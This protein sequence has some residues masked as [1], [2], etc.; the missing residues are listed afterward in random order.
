MNG[1]TCAINGRPE[2]V[3]WPPTMY[4]ITASN[5]GGKVSTTITIGVKAIAP[6]ELV[7]TGGASA[8]YTAGSAITI[9]EALIDV[10]SDPIVINTVIPAL[11]AG[12]HFNAE[13]G[14]VSGTPTQV[15]PMKTYQFVASNSGGAAT[16]YQNIT[17]NVVAP[18]DL[19]YDG[20]AANM[21]F[22]LGQAL[23]ETPSINRASM[24]DGATLTY[25]TTALPAG[26]SLNTSTG[27]FSGTPT[28]LM[29]AGKSS[30]SR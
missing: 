15:T 13:Y 6:V 29:P 24:S 17:V 20:G 26:L 21:T 4:S 27:V 14:I 25:S 12:L 8:V 18:S 19:T 11:P 2:V 22:T 10:K 1:A 9:D 16:Y 28:Q 23:S 5:T 30:P 7:Y 3:S